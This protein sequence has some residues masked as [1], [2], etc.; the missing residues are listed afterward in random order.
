MKKVILVLLTMGILLVGV[1]ALVNSNTV[2]TISVRG[3]PGGGGG[4][5]PS[6]GGIAITS[7][8]DGATVS[9]VVIITVTAS[10]TPTVSIDGTAIGSGFSVAWDTTGVADGVHT[11]KAKAKKDQITI[12]VTVENGGTPPPPAGG[13]KYAL[14]IG[15]SDY[16]GRQND[17]T[18][19][20]D[21]AR[22]MKAALEGFGYEVIILTDRQATAD[23]IEAAFIELDNL[24]D[25]DSQVVVT[26]SGH[27][28]WYDNT[29]KSCWLS[30]DMWYLTNGWVDMLM[31]NLESTSQFIFTDACESGAF[32][33]GLAQNGR[34]A[35]TGASGANTYTYDAPG[36]GNGAFTYY[37]LEGMGMYSTA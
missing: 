26:Y 28:V 3:K 2:E 27:G 13:G 14:V 4:K 33:T 22:D 1:F 6:G 11:I 9:D 24:E 20:D 10:R 7:P 32:R 5:P 36:L 23:G 34:L 37:L 30:T 19:C 17:L 8:A 21:D 15:I 25:A 16:D 12:T 35:L 18:Y 31:D 29:E